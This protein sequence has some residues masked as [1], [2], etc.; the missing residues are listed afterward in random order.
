MAKATF[1]VP[2]LSHYPEVPALV[3]DTMAHSAPFLSRPEF[4]EPLGFPGELME[5]WQAKALDK[6]GELLGRYRSLRVYLDA[7]VKCGSCTDKCHYYLGT[8]DPKNMPVGRQDLMRK[9]YRRYFTLAGK[10]FPK[11]VGAADFTK[12]VLDEWYSYY[13]QCSQCRRC[14][15]FCPYGIDT[16]EISMAAREIMDSI[17]V[18]Q[19]YC[20]EIIAKVYKIGNNL[21]LPGPALAD[22]LEGLEEDVF[23]DTGVQVRYPL[24]EAGAEILLITP[25]ADFFAEPHVDGLIGYGKVF[26]E[27]GVSW[28]LSSHASEAANF[29]MFIGSYE[30]MRRVAQRIREAAIKLKVK[31]IVFG[32]CG[33]AWRVAYSFLNT[34]AG[35]WDF[36][37]PRYPVPQ[38]ICE[39]TYDL[40]QRGKL[41]FDKSQNDDKVLTYHD[42]CNVARASR[43]GD[44]PGG[45]FEIP[46]AILRATC[47]NFYDMD[48]ETIRDRT[49]CCGGGGGLLTDD[50]MEL[51]VKGAKPRIEALNNV[52]Q[53]KGVTHMAAI[54]AICKSQFT[55]VL[56]YYGM[57]MDQIVSLHQ[58]VSNAIALTPGPE[59][60]ARDD[61]DDDD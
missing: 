19:K 6:M 29:G 5:N 9:V 27:A 35:P 39:F 33:H 46:R 47:N 43:M 55:K 14:S 60:E 3:P 37:D 16:A 12:E 52:M 41:Q 57:E 50:L 24:D 31:R 44:T 26:H 23:D 54:C 34:L 7:C 42:S 49:F 21:G 59:D 2:E 30:N 40:I 4:Q 15:V 20:N 11:L 61:E 8:K 28:T 51:R 53:E 32:E 36:L 22:T 45:Q 1:D 13:H 18:G 38:H 56:P 58:L 17:G 48:E 10:F 25:S